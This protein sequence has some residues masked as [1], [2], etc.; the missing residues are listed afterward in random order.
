MESGEEPVGSVPTPVVERNVAGS[1]KSSCASTPP[2]PAP[3]MT[4]N[5]APG[6][7]DGHAPQQDLLIMFDEIDRG[8]ADDLLEGALEDS[9]G[10]SQSDQANSQPVFFKYVQF[11]CRLFQVRSVCVSSF[12]SMFSLCDSVCVTLLLESWCKTAK[13]SKLYPVPRKKF[14]VFFE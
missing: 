12:S 4:V 13:H 7:E 11:V 10:S 2:P 6:G 9:A 3:I 8:G 14:K 5:A 1:P